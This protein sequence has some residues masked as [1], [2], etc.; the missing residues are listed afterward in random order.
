[1][2][3]WSVG[4][5]A[6][7]RFGQVINRSDLI[8]FLETRDYLDYVIDWK[9]RH[10]EDETNT[11]PSGTLAEIFPMTPRSILIA[12]DIN[13]TIVQTDCPQWD[14]APATNPFNKANTY[15]NG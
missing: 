7:L 9:W 15:K 5:F 13:V 14:A 3:P 12:G 10:Q 2:A 6:K 11:T 8:R 1:M 4:E